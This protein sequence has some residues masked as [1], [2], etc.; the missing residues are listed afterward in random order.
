MGKYVFSFLLAIL[1][2]CIGQSIMLNT[3]VIPKSFEW[4]AIHCVTFIG[5]WIG[6]P[7]IRDIRLFI[8]SDK[9][10]PDW[11]DHDYPCVEGANVCS[12]CGNKSYW[13]GLHDHNM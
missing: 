2:V 9:P 13:N 6:L 1:A 7:L 11:C 12:K 3:S 8:S 4:I 10:N 5:V